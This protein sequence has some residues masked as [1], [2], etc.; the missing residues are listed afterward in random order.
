MTRE[1]LRRAALLLC[2][3][4]LALVCPLA[5]QA[6]APEAV[7]VELQLG[8]IAN[9]TVEA[10][11]VGD[12][13]LVPLGQFLDLAEIQAAR[14]ADGGV[15]ATVQ[16]GNVRLAV[17]PASR[18]LR[19]GD[20]R[21]ALG[22]DRLV[23]TATDLYLDTRTLA[24]AFSLDWDVSWPDLQVTVVEPAT[25]PVARRLRREAMMRA[26]LASTD[27]PAGTGLRLGLERP[28]VNGLVMDYSILAPSS[29][30]E[31]GAYSAMV[32]LDLLG[33]SFTAG[34]ESQSG[35]SRPPRSEISWTGVWRESPYLAQLQLGDGIATGP[36]PRS[37]RG[38]ALSNSP[39]IRPAI[40]G[41]VPFGGQLGQGWTV[42]AYRGGRLI[43]YDSV[44]ALGRFS[45]DVP[46][47]YGE[48]PVDFVA[49]GPFGE[50]REFN[51]TYRLRPS[52]IRAN[53]LEYGLSLGACRTE[54]CD[55]N[56]NLDL[57][58]GLSTRWTLRA[59]MDRF[60]RD[61]L[62]ALT[63]P[64]AGVVGTVTNSLQVEAE[65]IANAAL[66]GIVRF[67]PSIN[68]QL[69]AE[70]NRFARGVEAPILTP[71]G[72][73]SQVTLSA[74]WRPTQGSG[75]NYVEAS[76][77]R[78]AAVSGDLLSTRL[79]GSYQRSNVR[80][81]PA[82]RVQRQVSGL[83]PTSTQTYL[84][85]NSLM[86]P[87]PSLGPLLGRFTARTSLELLAGTGVSSASAFLGLPLSRWFRVEA[88]ATWFRG[89]R[90]AGVQM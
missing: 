77:D 72:R 40:M 63:H 22:A 16:P 24:S 62:D 45:F 50:M 90:G 38:V 65:A 5:A 89:G 7:L 69:Q 61:S 46:I 48:N 39:W 78:I 58:Y 76:V 15:E 54:R 33:G 81:L 74:F 70:V 67:E 1:R 12:A 18:T 23:V 17:D 82:I 68:F 64:Y 56:G 44:N 57:R 75:A 35:A 29:G 4:A 10:Y 52:G 47:E 20:Q 36:R 42:E 32:G 3:L 41:S 34:L 86:L 49:Y 9:R 26:Q 37:V 27:G 84:G 2:A 59:G 13:A 19:L 80:V 11:R 53:R 60:W 88:G 83:G 73:L 85:F 43:G 6:P 79:G 51:Q 21:Y 25:L 55:A 31:S 87:Q 28:P 14:R 71:A 30:V 8:R 66:R